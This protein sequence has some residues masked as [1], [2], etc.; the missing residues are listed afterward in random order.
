MKKKKKVWMLI[1]FGEFFV[2]LV[3]VVGVI[4][5]LFRRDNKT[6]EITLDNIKELNGGIMPDYEMKENGTVLW[7]NGCFSERK[8]T[9]V[10]EAI[11]ALNDMKY[12]LGIK[13]A[14]SELQE[15]YIE[16]DDL[17]L[18]CQFEQV[19][20]GISVYGSMIS[21]WADYDGNSGFLRADCTVIPDLFVC[22]PT[23]SMENAQMISVQQIQS[24]YGEDQC[25]ISIDWEAYEISETKLKDEVT[26]EE[27]KYLCIYDTGKQVR[28]AWR[29]YMTING[30]ECESIIDAE[31]GELL[32]INKTSCNVAE[33]NLQVEAIGLQGRLHTINITKKRKGMYELQDKTRKIIMYD[34][35]GDMGKFER[36]TS[37]SKTK[38]DITAVSAM[39]HLRVIYDYYLDL[40]GRYSY[41]GAR[42]L[43]TASTVK[44]A[45]HT[46][47][48]DNSYWSGNK[49]MIL[50]GTGSINGSFYPMSFAVARDIIAHEFTHAVIADKTSLAAVYYGAAGAINEAYADIFACFIEGDWKIGE[51]ITK[52]KSIRDIAI[53]FN[54]SNPS[55]VEGAF[56]Q[57]YKTNTS[58]YGGIHKNSTIISHIAYVLYTNGIKGKSLANLW[59]RSLCLG[60][61]KDADFYDVRVNI[62]AAANAMGFSNSQI[63]I[64]K[65]AFDDANITKETCQENRSSY[66]NLYEMLWI[67]EKNFKEKEINNL[68][69]ETPTAEYVLQWENGELDL[70]LYVEGITKEGEVFL[71]SY[72]NQE[73]RNAEGKLIAHLVCDYTKGAATERIKVWCE[74]TS[75]ISCKVKVYGDRMVIY[76]TDGSNYMEEIEESAE[77]LGDT[78][79]I[80]YKKDIVTVTTYE[81]GKEKNYFVMP[82][83]AWKE[84]NVF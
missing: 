12:L 56:Y 73:Y 38:W 31:K 57:D 80:E 49:A 60:Y 48:V 18:L 76:K 64:I 2:L 32:L 3:I 11:L 14:Q 66:K 5:Y 61:G 4:V 26:T 40:T 67:T 39:S 82:K 78:E 37:K 83:E 7:I 30:E 42:F 51:D 81:N 9:S 69:S 8:I 24:I 46:G 77:I 17:G 53:P 23:I 50:I 55:K 84:W 22:K 71:I 52:K 72:E 25:E 34:G 35:G 63:E 79:K 59:Y 75:I 15:T 21:L 10:E 43:V 33:E 27:I 54:T 41:N 58:D 1:L 45:V 29:V 44:A 6:S 74:G 36:I 13:D 62:L 16:E 47:I 19:Y 70:D 20:E 28:L 68:K 65:K